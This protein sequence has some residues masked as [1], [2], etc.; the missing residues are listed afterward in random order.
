MRGFIIS[1]FA[2]RFEEGITQLATWLKEGKLTYS[3]IIVEG[4][5]NIPQAFLNLF[6]GKNVGKMI[7]NLL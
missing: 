7:V 4:F 5:E 6:E 3:E 2:N 1:D